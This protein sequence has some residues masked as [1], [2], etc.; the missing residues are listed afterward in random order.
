VR[1]LSQSE[2]AAPKPVRALGV[3]SAIVWAFLALLDRGA[4]PRADIVAL[5]LCV[6][7]AVLCKPLER[8]PQV[9]M[10]PSGRSFVGGCA[11]LAFCISWW[12]VRYPMNGTPVVIDSGVYLMQARAMAHLHFG[13]ATPSPMQAFSNHFVLE[14]PDHELY[15]VFPPGWPLAIV[16]FVWIGAPMLA[17]PSVA[18]LLVMAQALLGR[19]VGRAAGDQ[20][21]GELAMRVSLLVSL[22]AYVRAFETADL[23]SH[24]LVAL[25]AAAAVAWAIHATLES[26]AAGPRRLGL[27]VGACVGWATATRLLDGVVVG[28][29]V[30]G[31]LAWTEQGR[32]AL[33]WASLGAAPFL[34]LLAVEQRCATGGWLLPTQTEYFARTDWPPDCHRLAIGHG[35]GCMV[36]HAI[37]M[38]DFG[39]GGYDLRA[40]LKVTHERAMVLGEDLLGFAP[41]LLLAFGPLVWGA[42]AVDA[43]GVAFLLAMTLAYALF[44]YNGNSAL[45]GA[46]H[47]FPAAPFV[48]LL[49]A[50]ASVALP[51]RSVGPFDAVR[52]RGA[53]IGGL[54]LLAAVCARGPWMKRGREL[55][56][57]QAER[58]DL[59]R[60]L[61]KAGD[62]GGIVVSHDQ[63]AVAAAFDSWADGSELLF[64]V[65]DGAGLLELRRAHPQLPVLLSA[66]G[67][68]IGRAYS[69]SLYRGVL[70]ELERVWPTFVRP[71]GLATKRERVDEASGKAALHLFHAQPG[72][73][74]AIPF[75]VAVPGEYLVHVRGGAG[76][77]HGDYALSVDDVPLADW[78]GFGEKLGLRDGERSLRALGPGRHVLSARCVGRDP[79]SSGYDAL[80]DAL[81]GEVP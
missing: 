21:S 24:A 10:A 5:A 7:I 19:A 61:A 30:A 59:R 52:A 63:T 9:L 55:N 15:G 54:L 53:G 12:V 78:H 1:P 57:E 2:S 75:E 47:L 27:A 14:G 20:I 28:V 77:D 23:M 44:Y 76:P 4:W 79:T 72:A 65:D 34:A 43:L 38:A 18:A 37:A 16:P 64:A 60:S 22:P 73:E 32:T 40:A 70:V 31:V 8:L 74:V 69:T 56:E 33:R 49:V 25:L 66:P 17:G 62:T 46:R 51:R 45:Y 6:A 13:M 35:V 41:L 48:W 68:V 3:A 36:E 42:S 71:S 50:R 81:V 80:L 29:A 39:S 26:S 58:S 11:A 67:D